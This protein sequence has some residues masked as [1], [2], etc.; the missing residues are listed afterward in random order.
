MDPTPSNCF[1]RG[2]VYHDAGFY[3]NALQG[4]LM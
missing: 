1:N 4:K 3:E 2:V